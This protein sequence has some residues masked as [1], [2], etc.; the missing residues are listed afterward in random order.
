MKKIY[1]IFRRSREEQK[2][3]ECG[4]NKVSIAVDSVVGYWYAFCEVCGTK[5]PK[6]DLIEMERARTCPECSGPA[7]HPSG[8]CR[9]CY[10][11]SR[12]MMDES[13]GE[14]SFSSEEATRREFSRG[15]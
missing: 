10:Q 7:T 15:F 11:A 1:D 13:T 8:L 4:S 12:E 5:G 3:P 9:D 14:K 2:C 6:K